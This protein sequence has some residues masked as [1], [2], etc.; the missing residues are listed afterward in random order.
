MHIDSDSHQ[1]IQTKY[2][3]KILE[4]GML[5]KRLITNYIESNQRY[6]SM[7][8]NLTPS[9]TP[10]TTLEMENHLICGVE[11][12]EIMMVDHMDGVNHH[13]LHL[14]V[15]FLMRWVHVLEPQS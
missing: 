14:L 1:K 3:F 8:L 9:L 15:M 13:L 6:S 5:S 2:T 4:H 7:N 12:L 11:A 10:K